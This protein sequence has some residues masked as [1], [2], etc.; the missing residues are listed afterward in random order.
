MKQLVTFS[1]HMMGANCMHMQI[2][3]TEV[4]DCLLLRICSGGDDQTLSVTHLLLDMR[5]GSE[6]SM[7]SAE[8]VMLLGASG[9]AL[10][11][12]SVFDNTVL[13]VGYDQ[14]LTNWTFPPSLPARVINMLSQFKLGTSTTTCASQR[15]R[16]TQYNN[17]LDNG[18][19]HWSSCQMTDVSDV[20]GIEVDVSDDISARAILYGQGAQTFDFP[21][22][23]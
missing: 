21:R 19:L 12:V 7:H 5:A 18:V 23:I 16:V 6:V 4:T 17:L 11:G 22:S 14:R 13:S 15:V 9:S 10:K 8:V 2:V 20:A 3:E 1:A